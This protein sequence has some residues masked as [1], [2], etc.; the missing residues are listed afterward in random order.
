MGPQFRPLPARDDLGTTQ[1][2]HAVNGC[3]WCNLRGD[4]DPSFPETL[5]AP[6]VRG[7]PHTRDEYG[8]SDEIGDFDEIG[9]LDEIRGLLIAVLASALVEVKGRRPRAISDR[10]VARGLPTRLGWSRVTQSRRSPSLA[11]ETAADANYKPTL[12]EQS[13]DAGY[14]PTLPERVCV[15]YEVSR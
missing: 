10:S 13:Q 4:E 15:F 5:K 9:G 3:N 14:K 7:R 11:G 8:D 2:V 12:P 6:P 1:C